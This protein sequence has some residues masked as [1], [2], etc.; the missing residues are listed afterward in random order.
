MKY[1]DNI[2]LTKWHLHTL[3]TAMLSLGTKQ[4]NLHNLP[5]HSW[6][7]RYFSRWVEGGRG[8]FKVDWGGG[9]NHFSRYTFVHMEDLGTHCFSHLQI[10]KN[11]ILWSP[12]LSWSFFGYICKLFMSHHKCYFLELHVCF[13]LVELMLRGGQYIF[14]GGGGG[15]NIFSM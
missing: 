3:L 8:F 9:A 13:Q 14:Q 7:G 10:Y 5:S 6:G 12:Y 4:L 15:M 2:L 1:E 11:V